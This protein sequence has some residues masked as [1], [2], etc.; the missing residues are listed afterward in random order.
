M[1]GVNIHR[2]NKTGT[3]KTV[4]KNSA[5]CQVFENAADFDF[6]LKLCT[7][8]KILYGNRF[9]YSLVDFRAVR[10][11]NL[12]YIF[13]GL[14]VAGILGLGFLAAFHKEKITT[15]VQEVKEFFSSIIHP[16]NKQ[17]ETTDPDGVRINPG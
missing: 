4:D 8:H 2:A 11:Q 17:H 9:T 13:S 7:K 12:R 6:F 1:Y 10:R 14:G 15:V 16:K 5:G 3:T